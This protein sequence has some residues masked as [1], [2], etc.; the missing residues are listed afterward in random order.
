MTPRVKPPLL[1]QETL[2]CF[3]EASRS[4]VERSSS[5]AFSAA[6][7]KAAKSIVVIVSVVVVRL[8]VVS[9]IAIAVGCT[10]ATVVSIPVVSIGRSCG[11]GADNT[12]DTERDGCAIVTA[13]API[14]TAAIISDVA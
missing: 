12:Q 1:R 7:E 5:N 2:G 6:C 8:T 10:V 13:I 4:L 14:T 11:D 3:T 9:R